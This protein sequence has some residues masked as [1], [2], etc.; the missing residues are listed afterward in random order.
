MRSATELANTILRSSTHPTALIDSEWRLRSANPQ[1]L[2]LL[3]L[4]R[5]GFEGKVLTDV[6]EVLNGREE[7]EGAASAHE[8]A[9]TAVVSLKVRPRHTSGSVGVTARVFPAF[10]GNPGRLMLLTA[11]TD[12]A[13]AESPQEKDS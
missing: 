7:L 9:P 11:D 5:H 4:P 8:D 12:G 1:I 3:R 10:D 6:V 13:P 2:A